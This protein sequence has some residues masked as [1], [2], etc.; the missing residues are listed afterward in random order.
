MDIDAYVEDAVFAPDEKAHLLYCMFWETLKEKGYIITD[1]AGHEIDNIVKAVSIVNLIGEFR[2]RLYDEVNETGFEDVLEYLGNLEIGEDEITAYCKER[3]DIEVDAS[4]FS[5]T[6]KN[7]L[8]RTTEITAE[9]LLEEYSAD[10]LFDFMFCATYDFVQ[11]FT[12]E[13]EDIDEFCAFV[14]AQSEKLDDYKEEY[15]SVMR[16]VENGMIC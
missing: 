10:D 5:N 2:Y 4:E 3:G 13:F 11:D 16:W 15:P 6:A 9:K 14:D 7:M 8:D 1:E 12:F